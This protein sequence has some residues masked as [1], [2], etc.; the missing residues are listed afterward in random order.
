VPESVK[1]PA[2]PEP[3][4]SG[5]TGASLEEKLK[6]LKR[7]REQNLITEEEYARTKQELL[8][9]FARDPTPGGS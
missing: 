7:L 2:V 1:P 6:N 3:R 5:A 8:K 4:P 9:D